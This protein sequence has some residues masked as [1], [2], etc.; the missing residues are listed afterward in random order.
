MNVTQDIRSRMRIQRH[1]NDLRVPDTFGLGFALGT[2]LADVHFS[3]FT[4][5]FLM[6]IYSASA[7][8]G[9]GIGIAAVNSYC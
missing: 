9:I 1:D 8:L 7:P 5:V 2:R 4:E 6:L 3:R